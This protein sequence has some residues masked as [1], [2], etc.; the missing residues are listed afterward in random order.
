MR[1]PFVLA[2]I[3]AAYLLVAGG[4]ILSQGADAP[5]PGDGGLDFA[6][7]LSGDAPTVRDPVPVT[8][9]DGTD[10]PVRLYGEAGTGPLVVMLHGSGWHGMQLDGLATA[11]SDAAR[12][13][14]P[15][16]RG[17]GADP[18]RRGDI[19]HEGQLEEDIAD[20]IGALR[21]PGQ[22][23]VLLGHSSGG[24][25][26][27]RF[28]GGPHGGGID[29]AVLLAP[30]IQHDAPTTRADAGGWARPL[31]R[32]IVG[33]SMLNAVGIT[34]LDHLTAVRLAMP[35]Q[36]LDGPLGAT[37]TTGYS[38]RLVKGYAPRRAYRADIAALPR[39]L[40]IAGREDEAFR[41]SEYEPLLSEA[42][43]KGTYRLLDGTGHL[44]VVDDP[45]TVALARDFIADP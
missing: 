39:F 28:A 44:D 15:D 41:A 22:R 18:Q 25:L 42:S 29:G 11:L 21:A 37:A 30:F 45:A 23:V 26:A 33:L 34:A 8:M 43:G 12:I 20:L 38:W 31:V 40:L 32:R 13:A 9:R 3:P 2:C 16:L 7:V 14:V 27:I 1:W 4:L 6:G 5:L 17:H 36:V 35:R 24:G 19:D 10:L